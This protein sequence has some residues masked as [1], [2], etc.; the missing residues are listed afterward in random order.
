MKNSTR[1][2]LSHLTTRLGIAAL[3]SSMHLHPA[4]C[5]MPPA[6]K[7][8]PAA[9]VSS[10]HLEAAQGFLSAKGIGG[11]RSAGKGVSE[12]TFAFPETTRVNTLV[13]REAGSHAISPWSAGKMAHG[14][15]FMRA[16]RWS[17]TATAPSRRS[18]PP[19]TA[20]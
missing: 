20:C 4:G 10:I 7:R 3:Y 1:Y 12:M 6:D 18:N 14:A 16:I 19:N 5:E 11:W 9:C 2:L 13:L 17:A 8:T 15:A